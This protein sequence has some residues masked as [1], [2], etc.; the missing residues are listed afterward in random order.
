MNKASI[1]LA[2]IT[3]GESM[4]CEGYIAKLQ[5]RAANGLRQFRR[6]L[7]L[8]LLCSSRE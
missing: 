6:K 8:D 5:A 4:P 7:M 1:F 2:G 3:G